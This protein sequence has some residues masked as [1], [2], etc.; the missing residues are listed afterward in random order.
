M[1]TTCAP[2]TFVLGGTPPSPRARP[3]E[4]RLPVVGAALGRPVAGAIA[5]ICAPES[6][7][8]VADKPVSAACRSVA[9]GDHDANR[10][11]R[12]N[13]ARGPIVLFTGLN[14]AADDA[15]RVAQRF[16]AITLARVDDHAPVAVERVRARSGH[17]RTTC[18]R[19][20]G[21]Q[22]NKN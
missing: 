18:R 4:Q 16:A 17:N 7:S 8:S 2:A 15:H 6:A 22:R 3:V 19:E 12:R 13:R 14:L 10:A 20:A 5:P 1:A 11:V 21:D 9:L